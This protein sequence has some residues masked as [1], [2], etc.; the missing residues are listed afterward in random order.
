[1]QGYFISRVQHTTSTI[2]ATST[3]FFSAP[4]AIIMM[5]S[6]VVV[7]GLTVYTESMILL[8]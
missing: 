8:A 2:K 6:G 3:S 7:C 4:K 1:M 5:E